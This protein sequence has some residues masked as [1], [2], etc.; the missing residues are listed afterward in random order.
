MTRPELDRALCIGEVG[1][2]FPNAAPAVVDVTEE[3]IARVPHVWEPSG[4][5]LVDALVFG[6]VRELG[7]RGK[8]TGLIPAV[9]IE[10]EEAVISDQ[11]EGGE[12]LNRLVRP[13][14]PSPDLGHIQ[15]SD[16]LTTQ[17]LESQ[18]TSGQSFSACSS[19][20]IAVS[21]SP[22]TR[23]S[24]SARDRR[25]AADQ[26]LEFDISGLWLEPGSKELARVRGGDQASNA[27]PAPATLAPIT[28]GDV[29][30]PGR[31]LVAQTEWVRHTTA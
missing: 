8:A 12:N 9:Q 19:T 30:K 31:L 18:C 16:R 24:L 26:W 5:E 29:R 22:S 2:G 23:R 4:P 11:P 25:S 28:V 1:Q 14:S 10:E 15:G 27:P 3:L 6:S 21:K 20:S 13:A 17:R 7:W